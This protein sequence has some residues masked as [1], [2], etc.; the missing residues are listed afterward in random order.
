MTKKLIALVLAASAALN[1]NADDS[2]RWYDSVQKLTWKYTVANGSATIAVDLM[3]PEYIEGDIVVPSRIGPNGPNGATTYPVRDMSPGLFRNC[4]NLKSV[5]L[6]DGLP[7]IAPN[8]FYFDRNSTITNVTIGAG[9][10]DICENAFLRCEKLVFVNIPNTVTNICPNALSLCKALAHIDIPGS[11]KTINDSA[12]AACYGLETVTFGDGLVTIDNDAFLNCSSLTAIDLPATVRTIGERAFYLCGN[13]QS[14]VLREGLET[15]GFCAFNQCTSLVNVAIPKSVTRVG[16]RA[17]QYCPDSIF[18]TST[19]IGV[20]LLSDWAVGCDSPVGIIDLSGVGGI[21]DGLFKDQRNVTQVILP[22]GIDVLGNSMFLGCRSLESVTLP[23]MLKSIEAYAFENCEKLLS[24]AIPSGVTNI[25][26]YAFAYCKKLGAITFPDGLVEMGD[27]AFEQ[28]TGLKTLVVPAALKRIPMCAFQ[29]CNGLTSVTIDEGVE[30]IGNASF[31]G[32]KA[33]PSLTIPN[34]VRIIENIAFSGCDNLLDTNTIVNVSMLDGWIVDSDQPNLTEVTVP[35]NVRGVCDD[36]FSYRQKLT[37]VVFAEGV[38]RIPAY[39]CNCDQS[40]ASV[41]M[42]DSLEEIA[43][44]AFN[45]CKVL[46]EVRVPPNVREIGESAF[47]SNAALETAYLPIALKG[48]INETKVF[49]G[50]FK[51]KVIYYREDGTFEDTF[52][53]KF[54]AN[55]GNLDESET[56]RNVEEGAAVGE[57]PTPMRK[58]HR[59]LGWFTAENEKVSASTIITG[60]VTYYAQWEYSG[61]S[62]LLVM[63]AEGQE[64]LGSVTGGGLYA[65]GKIVTLKAAV[66]NK[67]VFLGW[68]ANDNEPA[69]STALSF[70]YTVTDDDVTITARFA[71]AADDAASLKLNIDN[72]TTEADGTYTLNLGEC[73]ESLSAPKLT[74]AGLPTG[75]KYD[76]K[77]M[78]VSGK[79]TKPGVY[80]VKVTASNASATGK[81]AVAEE[82]MLTVPN[83]TT[84]MFTAAGLVSND[85]YLLFAGIAPDLAATIK[86]ITDDGWKLAVTGLPT[87]LKYNA[88]KGEIDGIATK[89]GF[90][91][92]TFAATKSKEKQIATATFEVVFP[93]LT[94]QTAVAGDASA[95]GN[96][97]GGGRYPFGKSVM[98]K[99]TANKGSVFAGWES[100]SI[101]ITGNRQQPTLTLAMPANDISFTAIFVTAAEDAASITA[102]VDGFQFNSVTASLETNVMSGVY[103]EWPVAVAAL[104][105]TTVK[106][107][108]LPA[109]LKFT[110]KDIVDTKTKA[111]TVPANT[112]YGIPTAASKVDAKSGEYVP[113]AVKLTASTTGKSS[114][115]YSIAL[116]VEP[117]AEW[118]VG[119][120]NGGGESGQA[121]VTVA[122][123]GKISGKWLEGGRTWTLAA[124]GFDRWD[125]TEQIYTATLVGTSGKQTITNEVAFGAGI[126]GGVA[127]ADGLFTVYQNNWKNEPWKT[128]G[129]GLANTVYAYETETADGNAGNVTLKLQANGNITVAAKFV[130]GVNARTEK[131]VVYSASGS[132]VLCPQEN[133]NCVAFVYLPPKAGKFG[134]YVECVEIPLAE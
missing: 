79:A 16:E 37:N 5:K 12:F 49:D 97:T 15:I 121:T 81:N 88:K 36:A 90:F 35:G 131:D 32:C 63:V 76:A 13:M 51:V 41:T 122:K 23:V 70:K 17:F 45:N 129:K 55:G 19:I 26:Q 33:I 116:T 118:A 25:G 44:F 77:T 50:S 73:V 18:D 82:F 101:A 4:V 104:S 109:G 110:A 91:T 105:Q 117:V 42:P 78:T 99:A 8:A 57:L 14:A 107:S 134:G 98:L 21:A 114:A 68:F 53:V 38:K 96:V 22:P 123:T 87:G 48:A 2:G 47:G 28:C 84:P 89:E 9:C 103:L 40:L 111:V 113:S 60:D 108:G 66:K 29:W 133:G 43:A 1:A 130:T 65:T 67:S 115:T 34:S 106:V 100:D 61:T 56:T 119:T 54:E 71:S 94:L 92:V 112:I 27:S 80:T 31:Y 59:F 128:L 46:T 132:A 62:E 10:L 93:T 64:A 52:L 120:F 20:Q 125:T 86:A 126:F 7:R 75:L 83:F 69:L 3:R 124:N 102:A 24:I 85:N 39:V 11:V 95:S 58:K 127:V 30:I 6:P 72:G 74:V